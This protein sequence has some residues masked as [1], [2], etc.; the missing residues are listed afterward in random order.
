[1][2]FLSNFLLRFR[3]AALLI[4]A[5]AL[6]GGAEFWIATLPNAAAPHA[7]FQIPVSLCWPGL[8]ALVLFWISVA[9]D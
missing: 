8:S 2:N 9:G 5:A 7:T 4:L 1:M 6:A 3:A